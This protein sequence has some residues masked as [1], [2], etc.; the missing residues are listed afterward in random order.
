MSGDFS[1]AWDSAG[2]GCGRVILFI[3]GVLLLVAC[4][5]FASWPR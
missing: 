1:S 4:I 3:F 2:Q 5:I